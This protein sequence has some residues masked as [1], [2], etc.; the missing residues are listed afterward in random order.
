MKNKFNPFLER[1]AS[2][3]ELVCAHQATAAEEAENQ[4][5]LAVACMDLCSRLFE[6]GCD[7]SPFISPARLVAIADLPSQVPPCMI[8]CVRARVR[9]CVCGGACACV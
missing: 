6:Q 9:W 8:V 3:I 5:Q 2:Q 7:L 4:Q 1:V